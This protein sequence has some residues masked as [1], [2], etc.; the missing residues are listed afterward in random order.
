VRRWCE[1]PECR[2][3]ARMMSR[4]QQPNPGHFAGPKQRYY[5]IARITGTNAPRRIPTTRPVARPKKTTFANLQ[6][7]QC[8]L[9]FP[10]TR[11]GRP[12][13]DIGGMRSFV[14]PAR[15]EHT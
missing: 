3:P 15:R 4:T 9:S 11:P 7:Y 14:P 6:A 13:T 2:S 8:H 12:C 5:L 10:Q 1:K